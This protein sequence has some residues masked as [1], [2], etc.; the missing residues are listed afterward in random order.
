MTYSILDSLLPVLGSG[1]MVVICCRGADRLCL[2]A[3][4]VFG[5]EQPP[6]LQRERIA[7]HPD[8]SADDEDMK[9]LEAELQGIED[10]I[11]ALESMLGERQEGAAGTSAKH[12]ESDTARPVKP[13]G[14]RSHADHGAEAAPAR[15]V[16]APAAS[17]RPVKTTPNIM[18]A[19]KESFSKSSFA[20][21]YLEYKE[22]KA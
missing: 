7:E 11:S 8:Y 22:K 9:A 12:G 3:R 21:A 17:E 6:L 10:E 16:K 20:R 1:A 4:Q 13:A 15:K 14:P 5:L 19:A 18:K 2:R